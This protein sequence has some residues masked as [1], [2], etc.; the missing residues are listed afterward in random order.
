MRKTGNLNA[1]RRETE[2]L[3]GIPNILSRNTDVPDLVREK[4]IAFQLERLKRLERRIRDNRSKEEKEL[5]LE[6]KQTLERH[7]G[8]PKDEFQEQLDDFSQTPG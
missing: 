5:R 8:P 1:A 4:L 2:R 3:T 7:Q 6:I